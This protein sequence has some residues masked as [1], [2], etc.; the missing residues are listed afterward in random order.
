MRTGKKHAREHQAVEQLAWCKRSFFLVMFCVRLPT[1]YVWLHVAFA[2]C[3]ALLQ[4]A[5][6]A[7]FVAW[8]SCFP[9]RNWCNVIINI[10]NS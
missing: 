1:I 5:H 10:I 2:L 4:F 7:W 3:F 6:L 9:C 8:L